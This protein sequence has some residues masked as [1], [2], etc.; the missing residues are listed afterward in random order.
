MLLSDVSFLIRKAGFEIRMD[1]L[2]AG[3]SEHDR[4]L[5]Q[6]GQTSGA[7]SHARLWLS[8]SLHILTTNYGL[9]SIAILDF[10][11][12]ILHI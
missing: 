7:P 5:R 11:R 8:E 9:S 12:S 6:G 4:C 2:V 1:G 3:Q 10:V